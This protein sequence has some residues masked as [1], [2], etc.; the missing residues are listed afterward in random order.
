MT[1]MSSPDAAN[2]RSAETQISKL[3]K[4]NLLWLTLHLIVYLPIRIWF[5]PRVIGRENIDNTSGG[6]LL[7]NHQSFLDPA[8]VGVRLMR[9]ISFLARDSL[10]KVPVLGWICRHTYVIPISRTAF[11]GG[12]IRSALQRLNEGF[13]IAMFPEGTRSSG[14]PAVFR[15]G[16]LSLARRADVPIYP[17]AVVGA[18]RALP[19]GAW[20]LRPA[21]ITVVYGEPLT[22]QEIEQIRSESDDKKSAAFVRDKVAA[23]YESVA[24]S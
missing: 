15:P 14:A 13:L 9:A 8:L 21:R 3:P 19:K 20:L 17:V 24:G 10:F 7:V 12:S 5:G 23:L 18:D 1:D 2:Q 11:R 6:I 4:R 16:F 22:P